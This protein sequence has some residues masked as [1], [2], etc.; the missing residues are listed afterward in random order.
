MIK[1]QSLNQSKQFQQIL[2]KDKIHSIYLTIYFANIYK[3]IK[4]NSKKLKIS[5]IVKKKIGNAVKRNKI[6]RRLKAAIQKILKEKKDINLNYAYIVFGREN[7]YDID[8]SFIYK[9][10]SK[11][12]NKIIKLTH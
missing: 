7:A 10:M 2:K 8:Y 9:E 12:F 11:V 4:M 3:N 5:F 1:L 6:K